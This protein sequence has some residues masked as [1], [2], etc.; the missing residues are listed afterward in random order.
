MRTTPLKIN[1][2]NTVALFKSNLFFSNRPDLPGGLSMLEQFKKMSFEIHKFT[3]H[4]LKSHE[5]LRSISRNKLQ[6]NHYENQ[7]QDFY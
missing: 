6:I 7:S 2:C 3:S 4:K 1:E 5:I